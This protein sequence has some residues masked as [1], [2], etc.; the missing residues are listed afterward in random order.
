MRAYKLNPT[1][2][3]ALHALLAQDGLTAREIATRI[4]VANVDMGG[5]VRSGPSA[6]PHS[7][8]NLGYIR[9]VLE[10]QGGEIR[11]GII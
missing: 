10:D 7:L 11:C 3:K 4:G 2:V 5:S 6:D 9:P 8:Y 1:Q